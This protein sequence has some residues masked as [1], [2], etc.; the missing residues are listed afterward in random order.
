MKIRS[1]IAFLL[2]AVTL[3]FSLNGCVA[4]LAGAAG[5]GTV[6]YVEGKL[7]SPLNAGYAQSRHAVV[8]AIKQLE[9]SLIEQHHD[10]L[11]A[12]FTARTASDKKIEIKLSNV[13][14][15]ATQVEIRVGFFGD[16]ELS[17]TILSKIKANLPS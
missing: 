11:N 14:P 17:L 3:A 8:L 6:A 7:E 9:F 2:T 10:A 4:V 16:R 15:T 13:S 5:A 12:Y 1:K